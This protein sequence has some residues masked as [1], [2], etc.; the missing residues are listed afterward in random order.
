MSLASKIDK[1]ARVPGIE[2]ILV[3]SGIPM[4]RISMRRGDEKWHGVLDTALD[5]FKRCDEKSIRLIIGSHTIA[6]LM[7][8]DETVAVAVP[9]GHTVMKSIRRMLCRAHRSAAPK[10]VDTSVE[11]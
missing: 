5:L 11:F 9:T 10:V 8:G 7:T 1:L 6:V 4:H 3:E 2:S